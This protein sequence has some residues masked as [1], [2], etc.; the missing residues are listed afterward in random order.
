MRAFQPVLLLGPRYDGRFGSFGVQFHRLGF[1][2]MVSC[3]IDEQS[4]EID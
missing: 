4:R 3:M 1:L 2:R